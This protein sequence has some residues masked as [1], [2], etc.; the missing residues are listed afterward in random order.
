ELEGFGWE[1]YE[2]GQPAD[3]VVV[4]ADHADYAG[5]GKEEF[6]G[7]QVVVDGRRLLDRDRFDGVRFLVVGQAEQER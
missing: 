7:V 2:L 6:P 5:L 4:Q 1:A 3:V